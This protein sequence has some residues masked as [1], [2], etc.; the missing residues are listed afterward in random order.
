MKRLE[1][2]RLLAIGFILA[3]VLFAIAEITTPLNLGGELQSLSPAFF[4]GV[5]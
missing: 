5:K 2:E 4:G 3:V 1:R